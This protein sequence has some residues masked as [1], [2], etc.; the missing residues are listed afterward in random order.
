MGTEENNLTKEI[1]AYLKVK[2]IYHWRNNT[3][4]RGTVS[5]GFPG[6]A[7]ILGLLPSGRFLAIEVKTKTGLQ[8][9]KQMEFESNINVNNGLYILARSLEDVEIYFRC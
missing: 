6:S 9:D 5:Y 2:Q 7:D 4:R 8:N 3:G 1:I